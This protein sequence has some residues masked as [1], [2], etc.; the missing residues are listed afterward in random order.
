MLRTMRRFLPFALLTAACAAPLFAQSPVDAVSA[1]SAREL[2]CIA[3]LHTELGRVLELLRGAQ[4]QMAL[5]LSDV[6]ARQDAAGSVEALEQRARQLVLAME[7]CMETPGPTPIERR[8]PLVLD[9]HAAELENDPLPTVDE[10]R[11][12]T[13]NV[14]VVAAQRVD[15]TGMVP[16]AALQQS[17]SSIGPRLDACYQ[18]LVTRGA[19]THGQGFLVFSVDERGHTGNV[20]TEGFT[21]TDRSFQRCVRR[22]GERLR[23]GAGSEGG[24][25]RYSYTL[26][27]GPEG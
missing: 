24:T 17:L 10:A 3:P 22:A 26:E 19:L 8:P 20:T 12:L 23:P 4:A 21:I 18:Q 5:A 6:R 9:V 2:A 11:A 15:G 16:S 27:F 14:R 1:R 7:A 13:D 25:S